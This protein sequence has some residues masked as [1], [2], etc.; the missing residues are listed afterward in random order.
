MTVVYVDMDDTLCDYRS[1]FE[2]ALKLN[3]DNKYPQ[4]QPQFFSNLLP[5]PNAID[6]MKQLLIDERYDPY[7]LTAPSVKN[8]LCYTE[9]RLWV[10]QHLGMA[11]VERLIISPDKGLLIGDYLVDDYIEGKGQ[12][13]FNGKLIHFSGNNF[14]DWNAVMRY[15]DLIKL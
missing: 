2:N 13:H 5:L 7:I 15:F 8:P 14:K 12:E 3:P 11:Y 9:K 10:E 4:S 6:A 1:A